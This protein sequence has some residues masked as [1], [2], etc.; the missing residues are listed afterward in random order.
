MENKKQ[1]PICQSNNNCQ[2]ED[3]TKDCWCT[4]YVFTD[5]LNEY[6]KTLPLSCICASC[7]E[8]LGAVNKSDQNM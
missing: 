3:Q 5:E 2:I 7:A 8:K 4:T 1:C 6:L